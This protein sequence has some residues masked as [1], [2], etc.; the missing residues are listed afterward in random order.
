VTSLVYTTG[1]LED[2]DRLTEFLI[3]ADPVS[4]ADTA[5]LIRQALMTLQD[6]PYIGRPVSGDM[7]ELVISRGRTGYVALYVYREALDAAFV[8]AVRHQRES[9]FDD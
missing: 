4:A 1:A 9:G 6:H 2:L 7:R 8:L 5:G 3:E